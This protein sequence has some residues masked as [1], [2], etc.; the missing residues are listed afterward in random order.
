MKPTRQTKE[1]IA[2][3]LRSMAETVESGDSFDGSLE[4]H[5]RDEDMDFDVVAMWRVG[6]SEGQGGCVMLGEED[7]ETNV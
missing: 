5:V 7:S 6:N 3:A 1:Q 2:A 4:Y